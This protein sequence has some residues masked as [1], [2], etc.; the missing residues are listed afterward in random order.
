MQES[1]F[2]Q[3]LSIM[4]KNDI[5]YLIKYLLS[6][7]LRR[8]EVYTANTSRVGLLITPTPRK[9]AYFLKKKRLYLKFAI[10]KRFLTHKR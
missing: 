5:I 4:L 9:T 2:D 8:L 3:I 7:L 6:Q 10:F 1:I